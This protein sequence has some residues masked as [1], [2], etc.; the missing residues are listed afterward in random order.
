MLLP[1]ADAVSS[2]AIAPSDNYVFDE[3]GVLTGEQIASLNSKAEYISS[4]KKLNVYIW[5][6]PLVPKEYDSSVS[7]VEEYV[8]MFYERNNLGYGEKKNG[9]VLMLETDDVP[10]KRDYLFSTYGPSRSVFTA[11][12]R[13]NL[14]EEIVPLF[15]DALDS[16]NFHDVSY[17]FMELVESRYVSIQRSRVI[18]KLSVVILVP[19]LIAL[20]VCSVWKR[21]MKSAKTA[22]TALNYIPPGG[23]N[24]MTKQ[25]LFLYRTVTSVRIESSSDSSSSDSGSS[26]GDHSSGGTV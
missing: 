13:E 8:D 1:F 4:M 18:F 5:I 20:I 17:T 12:K 24:L 19:C 16:G 14:V 6:I 25:D 11:Q 10:G 26:S 22:T 15:I 21:K 3:S 2:G 23:F 9:V 7:L